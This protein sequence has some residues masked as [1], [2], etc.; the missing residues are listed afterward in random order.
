MRTTLDLPDDLLRALKARAAM[1]G[2]TLKE[3]IQRLVRAGLAASDRGGVPRS[4]SRLPP[5]VRGGRK[6]MKA[7][8]NADL[9]ALADSL[10]DG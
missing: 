3:L 2:T 7:Y 9:A 1:D 10:T 6:K 8:T 4:P 5:P